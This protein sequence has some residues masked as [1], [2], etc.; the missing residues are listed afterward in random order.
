MRVSTNAIEGLF[1]RMKRFLR[2]IRPPPRSRST[3]LPSWASFSGG[4]TGGKVTQPSPTKRAEGSEDQKTV[5][6]KKS[7]LAGKGSGGRGREM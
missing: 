4:L 6:K 7:F 2:A 3:M 5:S 1:S